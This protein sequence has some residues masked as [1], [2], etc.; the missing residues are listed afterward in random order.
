MKRV[1]L[2]AEGPSEIGHE[3]QWWT[4][5]RKRAKQEGYFQPLLRRLLGDDVFIDAQR[6]TNLKPHGAGIGHGDRAA[7]ARVIAR[8]QGYDV[9]VYVKDVDRAGG[10]KKSALERRRKLASVR[11]EIVDGFDSERGPPTITVTPCR[12]LRVLGTRRCSRDCRSRSPETRGPRLPCRR[13]PEDTWGDEGE[14]SS[15]HPKCCLRRALG[16]EAGHADFAEFAETAQLD[17]VEQRC[18]DS[19]PPFQ[20]EAYRGSRPVGTGRMRRCSVYK[21]YAQ[22]GR[23]DRHDDLADKRGLSLP[24]RVRRSRQ[25]GEQ[26]SKCRNGRHHPRHFDYVRPGKPAMA[27]GSF[28]VI[29]PARHPQPAWFGAAVGGTAVH[30]VVDATFAVHPQSSKGYGHDPVV[31]GRRQVHGLAARQNRKTADV[32]G[33][34][35]PRARDAPSVPVGGPRRTLVMRF[36]RIS[37]AGLEIAQGAGVSVEEFLPLV[38]VVLAEVAWV[39]LGANSFRLRFT[40]SYAAFIISRGTPEFLRTNSP[41]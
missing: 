33:K 9:L 8:T 26:R 4:S 6:I 14:P 37:L 18:P 11:Q 36:R 35:V 1:L 32:R 41:A 29:A 17:V 3:D 15:G 28:E 16:R 12:M 23:P 20:A 22:Q 27:I 39:P 34:Y 24:L 10:T 25:V 7:A 19:F 13:T 2:V 30:E 31:G 21:A 38:L 5:K 40:K